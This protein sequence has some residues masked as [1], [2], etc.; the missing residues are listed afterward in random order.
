VRCAH[1]PRGKPARNFTLYLIT[2]RKLAAARGGLTQ[3]CTTVLRAAREAGFAGQVAIQLRE[4]DLPT[5]EMLMLA[6]ELRRVCTEMDAML[7]V[8]DRIDI[9][10]AAGADGVHLPSNSFSVAQAR[11]LAGPEH[12][13]GVSTHH[14][15][16][17]AAA[18]QAGADFAVFGPV[19]APLSKGEYG[20]PVGREALRAACRA[21]TLPIYALG[22]ITAQ[23]TAALAG[24]N[25]AGVAVIGAIMGAADPVQ[26][27]LEI[28]RA[29]AR[30]P[31]A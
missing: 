1:K 29:L 6:L 28:L 24:C 14:L 3:I 15:E 23:R 17:V 19:F 26:T 9:A 30:W 20:P 13:I 4:K 2:E 18:A 12:L 16:E 22:G 5:R 10:L 7:L 27:A 25:A 8:N 31:H 11:A 21:S